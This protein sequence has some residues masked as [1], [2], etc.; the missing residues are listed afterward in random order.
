MQSL[1]DT[2]KPLASDIL[3]KVEC[4]QPVTSVTVDNIKEGRCTED[5]LRIY[6]SNKSKFSGAEV[7]E[8]K[9]F[10]YG[11]ALVTFN[12]TDSEFCML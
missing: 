6:F 7:K 9:V 10:G 1:H 11:R 8:V 12:D 2:K 5:Y 4:L 3:L